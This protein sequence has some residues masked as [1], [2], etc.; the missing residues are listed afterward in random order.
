[1]P[2]GIIGTLIV[3]ALL[4]MGVSVVLT[5]MVNYKQLDVANPVA[6][7][8]KLVNQGW[9]ADLL[10]IGAIVGMS[11]MM[12]T[13]IYSSSRLIYSIGRDGLL[14]NFLGKIDKHGL[15]EN[16]LWIVTIVIALMG[17]LFSLEEL[18]SLVSIGTLL[19]FTF[20]SF[21]VILLRRRKDIPEG[22]FKVPFYPII[23]I[24]SGLACI[25]MMCFYQL[26][27]T[28]LLVF[29]SYLD[30]LFTAFM[31]ISIARLVKEIIS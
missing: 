20:V 7:A 29:G 23:P 1:M 14:P 24:L 12:L 21:G 26:K 3:A 27:L 9:V 6:Y 5:G 4:Y 28:F 2:I 22:D 19:A 31:D 13:M 25:G 18:T 10:S 17:G 30:Y 16:A 11:T 8:L 15:P